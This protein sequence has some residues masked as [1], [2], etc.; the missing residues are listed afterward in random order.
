MAIAADTHKAWSSPV[1]NS[2]GRTGEHRLNRQQGAHRGDP[3]GDAGFTERIVNPCGQTGR[4][5]GVTVQH[6][7]TH[8][9]VVL[10]APIIATTIPGRMTRFDLP[11]S[12]TVVIASPTPTSNSEL[13]NISH[14]WRD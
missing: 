9:G 4:R 6:Q 11:T 5:C 3:D 2:C 8:D 14:A 10:S 13:D 7:S 12:A 1:T